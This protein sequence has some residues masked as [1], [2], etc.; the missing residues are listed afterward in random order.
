M[1]LDKFVS[2]TLSMI[3]KGVSEAQV[4][5]EEYG[6][7][8]NDAPSRM[9]RE[10]GVYGSNASI[11]QNVEFDVAIMTEDTSNGEGKISVMGIGVGGG[12]QSKDTYTSRVKFNVPVSF[13]RRK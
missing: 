3:S 2:K 8:I 10:T 5:C 1:E 13:A 6:A 4:E 9:H 7:V 11:M 12:T